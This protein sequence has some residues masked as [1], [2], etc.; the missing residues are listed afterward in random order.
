MN[1]AGRARA[2][3]VLESGG[4]GEVV[5]LQLVRR[6]I[7]R[8]RGQGNRLQPM[9]QGLMQRVMKKATLPASGMQPLLKMISGEDL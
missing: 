4:E 7:S 3:A 5:A 1:H 8:F 9:Q 6:T 2:D